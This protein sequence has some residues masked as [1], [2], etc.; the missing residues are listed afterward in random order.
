VGLGRL[1]GLF[2]I[3]RQ[4]YY[5]WE[6]TQVSRAIQDAQ[7]LRLV[8][9]LRA[10]HPKMGVRKLHHL[11]CD[12]FTRL[13]IKLG[14]DGL[15][16]LLSAYNML[17]VK[18]KR[19]V[20]T[21][22]SYHRFRKYPNLIKEVIPAAAN[23]VW[24]SDITYI[25][26]QDQFKYLFLITDAYSRKVVG[27]TLANNLDASHAVNALQ[28]AITKSCQPL[29][30]LIHHSDRGIQ[31]CAQSYIRLLEQYNI[32]PSMTEE[33]DPR[34][35]AIAERVNGILKGEYLNEYQTIT[36][37][38]VASAIDKY[39]HQRPHLSCEMC[40]PAQAHHLNGTLK[41]KWKN[42]YRNRINQL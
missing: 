39:N 30:G 19:R 13:G 15:F 20:R 33:S 25:R 36:S 31:Y 22:Y 26:S 32:Q 1:S 14:R 17:I 5:K 9:E 12:D 28:D 11:L 21:T 27:H 35:N 2:G 3:S 18:R 37:Y 24:V 23:Q 34:E 40:T 29:T 16:D 6:K 38:T 8:R 10:A 41:R 42:Y 4:G 7:V